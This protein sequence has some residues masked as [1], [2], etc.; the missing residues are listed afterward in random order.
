VNGLLVKAARDQR[1]G[2]IGWGIG[3]AAVVLMY[4][5]F[6]PSI[7][8]SAADLQ[9]YIDNLPEA[10]RS[11]VAGED[12][13]SPTGYLESEFFNTMGPLVVLIFAIGAGA[14]A[15]AGEEEAGTL[16]LLLSTPVRRRQVLA[17][18]A[19]AIVAAAV[20]LAGVAAVSIAVLGPVFD[21]S[22]PIGDVIAACVMLALIGLS[23]GGVAFAVGAWTGRRVL[24]NS[25][26]GG[27]AVVAFIVHAVGR[28]VDWLRPL[29]PLS[30]FR[31]YQDPAPL[32]GGFHARNV[33]VLVGVALVCYAIAHVTF[34]RRDLSS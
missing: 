3:V 16:D 25:V 27:L 33:L 22:V 29:R 14:R 24:A 20:A 10:I 17:T 32:T 4:A 31:W 8:E 12:Y 30:P 15:I 23:F 2:M 18:K 21:L 1:R 34:E 7:K 26:A 5:A 28:T 9:A 13:A 19:L 6:Y 11:I